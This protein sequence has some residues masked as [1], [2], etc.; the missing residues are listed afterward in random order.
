MAQPNALNNI[1]IFLWLN[2]FTRANLKSSLL[3]KCTTGQKCSRSVFNMFKHNTLCSMKPL[4]YKQFRLMQIL[5]VNRGIIIQRLCS[6]SEYVLVFVDKTKSRVHIRYISVQ[7]VVV[8]PDFSCRLG[9]YCL[10]CATAHLL[11]ENNCLTFTAE[12]GMNFK[13]I[14]KTM[15]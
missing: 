12:L 1:L 2:S 6:S 8:A 13:M 7:F 3:E 14:K 5:N 11:T 4:N 10:H 9:Y 15:L